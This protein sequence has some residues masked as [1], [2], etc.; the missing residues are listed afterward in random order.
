MDFATK[1]EKKDR[2]IHFVKVH[3]AQEARI[4]YGSEA[5]ELI[6]SYKKSRGIK[7]KK[8]SSKDLDY[9]SLPCELLL[10]AQS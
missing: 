5:S 1:K 9:L 7:P 4:C 2:L 8:S 3:E 10:E 6:T